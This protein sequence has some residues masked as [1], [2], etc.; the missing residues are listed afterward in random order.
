MI[1]D[2][3]VHVTL[4]AFEQLEQSERDSMAAML[5]GRPVGSMTGYYD[6]SWWLTPL[7][8]SLNNDEIVR[9]MEQLQ[10]A[11]VG[12]MFL[13]VRRYGR[14]WE[15]FRIVWPLPEGS[16]TP[17]HPKLFRK[18]FKTYLDPRL[19]RN[20]SFVHDRPVSVSYAP[21]PSKE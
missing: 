16:K 6:F 14:G 2:T 18:G 9:I 12:R 13:H 5:T 20:F 10:T 1:D 4:P 19:I 3:P 7:D 17:T 8:R 15:S 11:G 21:E